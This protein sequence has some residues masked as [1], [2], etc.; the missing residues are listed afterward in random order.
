MLAC[1]LAAKADAIVSGD[2]HL[3]ALQLS[4]AEKTEGVTNCDYL[5]K[6]KYSKALPFAFTVHGAIQ[7]A[8]VLNAPRAV[9]MGVYVVR[10]FVR[11]REVK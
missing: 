11:L 9:E 7:A 2:R 4:P 3:L 6:L 8:N 10:A 5:A 1:A